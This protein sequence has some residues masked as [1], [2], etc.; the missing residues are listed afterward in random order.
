MSITTKPMTL[1]G[2]DALDDYESFELIE[3]ELHEL[4]ATKCRHVMISGRVA[5]TFV[6]YSDSG[7]PGE[8]LID[9]GG[10]AFR[11][12][13]DSLLVPDVAFMRQGNIPANADWDDWIRTSPDAAVGVKSPSNTRKDI[14]RKVAISLAGGDHLVFV[15]ETDDDP[16]T[17]HDADG[18]ALVYLIGNILDGGDVLRGFSVPVADIFA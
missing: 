10:F 18:H 1:K 16:I 11:G 7:L 12:G 2:F 4:A 15:A 3:G 8:V 6:R 5:K 17:A 9:E 13:I 14:A